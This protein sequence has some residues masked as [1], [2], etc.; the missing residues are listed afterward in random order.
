MIQSESILFIEEWFNTEN[1]LIKENKVEV[2]LGTI[3]G[4][5]KKTYK[6][7]LWSRIFLAKFSDESIVRIYQTNYVKKLDRSELLKFPGMY[8][9]TNFLLATDYDSGTDDTKDSEIYCL[10]GSKDEIIIIKETIVDYLRQIKISSK[11]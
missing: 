6:L 1:I 9:D 8:D 7:N 3:D 10:K 4:L 11:S 5:I 2:Y